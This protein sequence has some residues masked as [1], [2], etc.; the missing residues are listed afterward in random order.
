MEHL[1]ELLNLALQM[2]DKIA[3]ELWTEQYVHDIDKLTKDQQYI[4]RM[5]DGATDNYACSLYNGLKAL[6][7]LKNGQYTNSD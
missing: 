7:E 3:D 5:I 4:I 2:T 1:Y 6:G